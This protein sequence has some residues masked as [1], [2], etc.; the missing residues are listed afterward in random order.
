VTFG[1]ALTWV[2]GCIAATGLIM[3][4]GWAALTLDARH[5]RRRE[6]RRRRDL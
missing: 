3:A 6:Q 2:L 4:A 1:Q 5:Q